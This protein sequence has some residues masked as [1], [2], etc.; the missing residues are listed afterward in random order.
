MVLGRMIHFFIPE[1]KIA[2][3]SSRKLT[4]LF[5]LLDIACV[6][7]AHLHLI[8]I[9]ANE[10]PTSCFIVQGT[11]GSM[12]SNTDKD[13]GSSRIAKLGLDICEEAQ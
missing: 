9:R 2:G 10:S 11:G 3:V 8:D 13:Y 4:V 12:A 6:S 5:V 7:L 1:R